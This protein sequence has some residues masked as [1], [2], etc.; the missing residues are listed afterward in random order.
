MN[1]DQLHQAAVGTWPCSFA[2]YAAHHQQASRY[3]GLLVHDCARASIPCTTTMVTLLPRFAFVLKDLFP[4]RTTMGTSPPTGALF[5]GS[6]TE[7]SYYHAQRIWYCA[8][9][10]AH[11]HWGSLSPLSVSIR[12]LF[13]LF[14]PAQQQSRSM[15]VMCWSKFCRN[16]ARGLEAPV[17]GLLE[18]GLLSNHTQRRQGMRASF[19]HSHAYAPATQTCVLG[20]FRLQVSSLQV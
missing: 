16:C 8:C 10:W 1:L 18:N 11:R 20:I 17:S 12:T 4:A 3:H 6:L 14:C 15:G 9:C 2:L 7:R 19:L 13:P 5:P